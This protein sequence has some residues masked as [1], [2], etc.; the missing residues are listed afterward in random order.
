MKQL[1]SITIPNFTNTIVISNKQ[2]VKP[3]KKGQKMPLKYSKF[4]GTD[5]FWNDKGYLVDKFRNIVPKN[6]S[7]AGTP[8]IWRVNFQDLYNGKLNTF[9]VNAYIQ[10]LKAYIQPYFEDREFIDEDSLGLVLGFYICPHSQANKNIDIDNLSALWFKACLDALKGT[11]I[12]DDSPFIVSKIKSSV[13]FVDE[14][15]QKLIIELWK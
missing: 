11:I 15:E 7:Q 10:K 14:S 8:K 3:Y 5:Y 13:T 4:I 9:A 6:A 1:L 2:Q 12:K